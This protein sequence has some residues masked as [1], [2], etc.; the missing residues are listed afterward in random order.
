MKQRI[1]AACSRRSAPATPAGRA[2]GPRKVIVGTTIFPMFGGAR[3]WRSLEHRL[4]EIAG[5]VDE[6]AA[7]AR[8]RYGRGPDLAV[9]PENA[10][11]RRGGEGT[12]LERA[13]AL[14][15]P[16]ADVLGAKAREHRTWLIVGFNR[17]ERERGRPPFVTNAAA[18]FDREGRVAGVYR[19]VFL[20][21]NDPNSNRLEGGK[22]PGTE[23]PV[24]DTD[25]GRL[26][27][28]ICWDL[29]YDEVF[30][31]FAAQ[32]AEILAWP[33]MSP[34]TLA[35]RCYARRYSLYIVSAT[36]RD[37]ASIFDPL[38][39]IAAMTVEPDGVVTHEL[40]LDYRRLHW[41]PGLEGGAALR[42][43]YGNRVGFRYSER[44]DH[45]L[46][47]SNDPAWPIGKMIG[48]LGFRE[49]A[50]VRER[51]RR[52]R[53]RALAETAVPAAARRP[54]AGRVGRTRRQGKERSP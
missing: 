32:G 15:G 46:F 31:A 16:V 7:D 49:E 8:R 40:D 17:R 44:E 14:E 28:L 4:G 35:P 34:Q 12:L 45:G 39:G 23:F 47:W 53:E 21:G 27:I 33:T 18:L 11:N 2:E 30:E 43:A 50:E 42:R 13:V 52:M 26:G 38:G 9:F 10:I 51:S 29:G 48:A 54:A 22:R 41:Q 3:P 37:N 19:K 20:S 25:F 36:P 24:F 1:P 5:R 6:I